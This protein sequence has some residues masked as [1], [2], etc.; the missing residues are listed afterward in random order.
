MFFTFN[1]YQTM[2]LS[3]V[4][5]Q[6][7]LY[8]RK[9]VA[10]FERFCI[11]A[12]V[13]GGLLF[14][15]ISCILYVTGVAEF[16]FDE[17]MR[18]LCMVFF[19]N[20]V[21]FHADMKTLKSG[22]KALVLYSLCIG[23]LIICQNMISI[24]ISKV[25]NINPLFGL[26]AGSISL[27]GGHGTSG[28]FGPVLEMIGLEG[29]TTFC[30]AAGAGTFISWLLSQTGLK[31]PIYIGA[32][33]VAAVLRNISE[34]T[35]KFRIRTGEINAMSSIFLNLF[36]GI[37]MLTMKLWQLAEL[38]LPLII[39]LAVQTIFVLFFVRFV[40]FTVMGHDYD[41]AVFSAGTCGLGLGATPTAMANMQA[42]CKQ[43]VPSVKA[44]LIVPVVGGIILDFMNSVLITFFINVVG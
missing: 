30:T 32:M 35:G 38:A 13:I 12:P 22:G 24:G 41:A 29:A 39:L 27:V 37:A 17:A 15:T 31:F 23:A 28:A 36:L 8:I 34:Y 42:L 20:C 16:A 43:Y 14:A 44:F 25:L 2:A 7:G 26:C 4:A 6:I 19:F 21:G 10:F 18:D 5:L 9:K 40:V 3:V 33:I 11:P 1:G